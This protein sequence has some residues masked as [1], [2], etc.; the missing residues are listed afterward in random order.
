M[1]S[2]HELFHIQIRICN[3]MHIMFPQVR[4]KISA[5]IK[6]TMTDRVAANHTAITI[7]DERLEKSLLELNCNVHPLDSISTTCR[8]ALNNVAKQS[9]I[10]S[11]CFGKDC[12]ASNLILAITKLRYKGK[13]DPSTFKCFLEE[14]KEKPGL[15]PRYVGNRFHIL[16]HC[17]GLIYH[18][19]ALLEDFLLNWCNRKALKQACL[20]DLRNM[21]ILIQLQALGMNLNFFFL[22]ISMNFK[23]IQLYQYF[24]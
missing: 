6:S 18:R 21:D 4:K 24:G 13:G 22:F 16:F 8:Q 9:G 3:K 12:P 11:K 2:Q 23:S 15:F 10:K 7:L 17:A 19:R 14:K 1:L 20:N 5:C